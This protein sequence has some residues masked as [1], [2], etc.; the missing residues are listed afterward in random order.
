VAG[1]G[2]TRREE[3]RGVPVARGER[4]DPVAAVCERRSQ[5]TAGPRCSVEHGSRGHR[6]VGPRPQY[7]A[8]W[9]NLIQFQISNGFKLY[10]NSF[11]H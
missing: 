6:D 1:S 5:I 4:G 8:A 10:S 11:K 7:R 9:Q 2:A 3:E